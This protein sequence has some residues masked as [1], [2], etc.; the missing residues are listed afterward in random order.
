MNVH[1][2]DSPDRARV[3]ADIQAVTTDVQARLA[4]LDKTGDGPFYRDAVTGWLAH[5]HPDLLNE[6]LDESG[7]PE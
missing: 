5:E 4:R 2:P 7:A 3:L 1:T 6:A